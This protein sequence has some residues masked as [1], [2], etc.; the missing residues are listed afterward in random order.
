[1]GQ[2]FNLGVFKIKE[3]QGQALSLTIFYLRFTI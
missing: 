3:K 2:A 1:M